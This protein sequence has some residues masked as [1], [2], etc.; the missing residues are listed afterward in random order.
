M[1]YGGST[2][3]KIFVSYT[4]SDREWA[5]WIGWHL[6]GNG[7]K[8]F[9][10]DWEIGAEENIAGWMEE[11]AKQADKV[12]GV[13]SDAY[14][15]AAYSQSERWSAFWEDPRGRSG[16]PVPIEVR[17]VTKWPQFVKPLKRL[18]LI[19]L[20]EPEAAKQLLAFLKPPQGPTEKPSFPGDRRTTQQAA[21]QPFTEGSE[22]IG[23]RPPT[24]PASPSKEERSEEVST[25]VPSHHLDPDDAI[26][27]IDDYEPRPVIFGRTEE[28]EMLVDGL[29]KGKPVLVAG[30]PGMGKTAVAT[31]ALYDPRAIERFGRRR[32]FASLETATEPRAILAKLVETLGLPPAADEPSLLQIIEAN[33]AEGAIAAILDN[34]ETVFE[35]NRAEAERLLNLVTHVPGL[36]VVVTIRGVPPPIPDAISID[37]MPKL[38]VGAARDAFLAVA[39]NLFSSD[40]D[41]PALLEALDGHALSI[42]LVAAQAIGLPSLKGIRESWDEAHAEILHIAGEEETRLTSVRASLSLSLNSRRMKATPLARRL[43]ALLAHLPGGLAHV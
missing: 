11:R 30:G 12:I 7:H 43:M 36:S 32:V 6:R 31:A 40:P 22:P 38:P 2:V 10:H 24:F 23:D 26:R 5:H 8:A 16:F 29:L 4:S 25:P 3:V 20:A 41:L 34:A 15:E 13:F 18:S 21:A 42:R 1:L 37:D 33:A 35:A 39:G 27:C 14:I 17:R 28:V 19:D 9:V